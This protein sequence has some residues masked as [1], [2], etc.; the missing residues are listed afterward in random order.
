M[1]FEKWY[2][3]NYKK[4]LVIPAALL[5]LCLVYLTVF[6]VQNDS[7]FNRGISLTGGT[8]YTLFDDINEDELNDFLNDKGINFELKIL[9][10]NTGRQTSLKITVGD[11][12]GDLLKEYLEE[13]LQGNLT[14]QNSSVE[15]TSAGLSNQFYDQ[16]I[17]AIILAFFWMAGVVF[18]I[19]SK[20]LKIKSLVVL[21]NIILGFFLGNFFFQTNAFV[22]SFGFLILAGA[23][24]YIY[25]KNSVPSFAVMLSA[26]A[27]IVMTLAVVNLIGMEISTAGIV[28]FLML[29]GYSVDTDILLTTRVT[30]K[31]N[32]DI[33]KELWGS[34]KTGTTMTMTS[35]VAVMVALIVVSGY[36]T[37]LNEIFTILLIGLGFDIFNTWIT[38]ASLIKWYAESKK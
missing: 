22:Y 28:A 25:I 23:I 36:G 37:I 10:D 5:V 29:I 32:V 3:G 27:D 21:L 1:K 12:E 17:I 24:I 19:F 34:F 30:K 14:E 38:N 33:N 35:I 26:F 15:R 20:G 8:T 31:R 9:K 6:N 4:L 18:L 2:E 11:E 13:F 16:L 7:L